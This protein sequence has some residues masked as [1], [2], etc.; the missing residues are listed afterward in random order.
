MSEILYL[1]REYFF[2]HFY[3]DGI[4]MG[5]RARKGLCPRC[6]QDPKKTKKCIVRLDEDPLGY[7]GV[8]SEEHNDTVKDTWFGPCS[9]GR[10]H[11]FRAARWW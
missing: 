11:S 4:R 2:Y 1:V 10:F 7:V 5:Q 3:P 6:G 8:L 9:D